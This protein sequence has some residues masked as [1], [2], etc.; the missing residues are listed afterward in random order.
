M[1]RSLVVTAFLLFCAVFAMGANEPGW[2]YSSV[3]NYVTV[4]KQSFSSGAFT[5]GDS[6][7]YF[8]G[9]MSYNF[10]TDALSLPVSRVSGT[11]RKFYSTTPPFPPP[12]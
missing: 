12:T 11:L 1:K 2:F 5:F 9:G 10:S 8:E 6:S 7:D 4:L 3:N